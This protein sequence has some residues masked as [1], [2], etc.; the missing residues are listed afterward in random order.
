MLAS[1]R[2]VLVFHVLG[3]LAQSVLAGQFL[4]GSDGAV[5]LHELTAWIV[6]GLCLL[7]ILLAIA[8]MRSGAVSLWLVIGSVG[9]L[10]G[11]AL[12]IGTGYGRFLGVHVPLGVLL[13]AG[14]IWQ[15]IGAFRA[16]YSPRVPAKGIPL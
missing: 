16:S 8:L 1:L 4:S 11:E 2:A 5:A 13:L 7:Q 9:V 3:V 14:L 12:Q 10:L 15:L 6:L